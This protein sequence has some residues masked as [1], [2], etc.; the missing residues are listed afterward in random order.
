MRGRD[1]GLLAV[2]DKAAVLTLGATG[3]VADVRARLGLRHRDRLDPPAGDPSEDLLLLL[4]G[5]EAL[6]GPRDDQADAVAGD[7]DEAAHGPLEEDARVDQ[8]A[9]RAAVGLVDGDPEPAEVGEL[10]VDLLAVQLGVTLGDA[11]A[12][13]LGPELALAEVGDRRLEVALLVG[14]RGRGGICRRRHLFLVASCSLFVVR[15]RAL[16]ACTRI[17]PPRRRGRCCAAGLPSR[18][19]PDARRPSPRS[20]QVSSEHWASPVAPSG[21]PFEISPPDGL[22]T[23]PS[24]P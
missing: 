19:R 7:R 8:P 17:Q 18:R 3:E 13:L 9:A 16:P 15:V 14:E 6:V 20:C 24:P 1:P 23:G 22:T 11:L 5:A 12:L 21:W 4:L 2:E 10:L